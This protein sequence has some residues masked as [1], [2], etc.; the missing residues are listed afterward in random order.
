MTPCPD[1]LDA[2]LTA[3]PEELA[4]HSGG[5]LADHVRECPACA[6][7]ARALLDETRRLDRA[8]DR[9]SAL[10]PG[11]DASLLVARAGVPEGSP[12]AAKRALGRRPWRA[13]A[14]A[15]VAAAAAVVLM[16]IARPTPPAPPHRSVPD[17]GLDLE[18]D[19]N[20]AV[21]SPPDASVTVLWHF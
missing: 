11:F 18:S 2:L 15:G 5:P 6:T 20:V 4:G 14:G 3:E 16:W 17:P 9:L 8:L 19:R 21:L 13:A 12:S 10:P 1:R 7:V